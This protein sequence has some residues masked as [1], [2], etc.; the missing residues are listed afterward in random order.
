MFENRIKPPLSSIGKDLVAEQRLSIENELPSD[1]RGQRAVFIEL[2]ELAAQG[3]VS[4][5][6]ARNLQGGFPVVDALPDGN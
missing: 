2:R 5:G 6:L 1:S 4:V 3:R